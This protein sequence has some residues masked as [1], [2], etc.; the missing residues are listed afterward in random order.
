MT[1][2]PS[3]PDILSPQFA[4]DPYPAYRILRA[5]YPLFHDKGTDSYLLSSSNRRTA[6]GP[7]TR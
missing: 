1:T 3:P 2:L 7:C 5:H 6:A 4:A